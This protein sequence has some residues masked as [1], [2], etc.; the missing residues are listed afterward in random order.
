MTLHLQTITVQ[1]PWAWAVAIGAKRIE[2]RSA[3]PWA[4][5]ELAVH[6]GRRW[7]ARGAHDDRLARALLEPAVGSDEDL[8]YLVARLA[9][10]GLPRQDAAFARG[11]LVAVT[12][13]VDAHPDDGS[14]C[15]PWGESMYAEGGGRIR[16]SVWHLQLER[17]RAL[18]NPIPV[19]GQLGVWRLPA[20]VEA[21]MRDQ[22][23]GV[24][25]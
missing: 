24:D 3:C 4:L 5:G 1:Q 9:R 18:P 19:A 7:S 14:C 11:A 2:N 17:T 23:A 16:T 13:L 15:R 21:A 10:N 25:A 8:D 20:D 22:L 6:A 12:E